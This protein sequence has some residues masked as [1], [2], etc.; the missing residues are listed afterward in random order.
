MKQEFEEAKKIPP[1]L[2]RLLLYDEFISLNVINF[3]DL[4]MQNLP[5]VFHILWR[6]SDLIEI[7]SIQES[8]VYS[9]YKTNIQKADF[10]RYI[11]L[12]Y[13][14]GIYLDL[15]VDVLQ[16]SLVMDILENYQSLDNVFFEECTLSQEESM[17]ST[18]HVIRNNLPESQL[19]IANFILFGKAQ[20]PF[21]QKLID[22]CYERQQ[23]VLEDYDVM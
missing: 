5:D 19:R 6:E 16:P 21:T 8:T 7:M 17:Q 12:K 20:S 23:D 10:G 4:S 14:G 22:L 9:A 13:Y 3:V 2:H 18:V 1:F 11:V 15:D